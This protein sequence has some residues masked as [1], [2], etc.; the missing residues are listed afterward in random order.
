MRATPAPRRVVVTGL[1]VLSPGGTGLEAFWKGLATPPADRRERTVEDF[2]PAPW[3]SAKQARHL[4]RFTQLAVVAAQLALD[5][6]GGV[7]DVPAP[8]VGVQLGTGIGG[9]GTLE[10][11]VGVLAARGPGRVSPFTIPMVMPNAGAAAVSLRYGFQGPSE[12]LTTACA[13]GTHSVAAGARMVAD[14]RCDVVLAGGAESSMTP[15]TVA[16]FTVMT[17]LSRTGLSR[18][19]DTGRD[20]FC[21]AEG[22]AVLV[23]EER[24]AALA[25]GA[26]VYGEVLGAAST[27]DAHHITAP[28][29]GGAGAAACM[30]LALE[31]AELQP[32][33]IRAVNA[34][35]TST[36][37]NDAAEAAAVRTVFGAG[38]VPVSS[39]KGVTGH[40]LGAAGALEAA[41]V[42]LSFVHRELPP[43][44]GTTTVDPELELDVVLEPR[45]WQP[46]PTISNSFGFGGHNGSLVLGPA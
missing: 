25:R 3:L 20:G 42:L 39:I 2:D 14:G 45:A 10:T 1:G 37:L 35:G 5:D 8:R 26:R 24:A 38:A 32:G 17:A 30:R 21:I 27:C 12:T 11:Q 44:M 15:T 36:P 18:P 6:C 40:G 34:H 22:A 19:F 4:D 46:G 33:D 16:A 9:V 28:S 31:D 7:P 13:A 29:P 43:T 41:S 23:L